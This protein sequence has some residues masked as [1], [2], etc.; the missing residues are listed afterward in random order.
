MGRKSD[1]PSRA[2]HGDRGRRAAWLG[3]EYSHGPRPVC[4]VQE[5]H[6]GKTVL[7]PRPCAEVL[8]PAK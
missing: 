3:V 8:Q 4:Q 1:R 2:H 6:Q 7:V 5:Q